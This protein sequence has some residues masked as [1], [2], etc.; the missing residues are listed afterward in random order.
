[1]TPLEN[2]NTVAHEFLPVSRGYVLVAA[3]RQI[4]RQG[5]CDRTQF[6]RKKLRL[7]VA[8][9]IIIGDSF[10]CVYVV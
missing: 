7:M 3:F 5:L 6:D 1:M 2:E 4:S 8:V 9:K 10:D